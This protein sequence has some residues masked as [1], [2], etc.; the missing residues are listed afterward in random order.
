MIDRSLSRNRPGL[1]ASSIQSVAGCP[2]ILFGGG[3]AVGMMAVAIRAVVSAER[4]KEVSCRVGESTPKM[5][6][7]TSGPRDE[8][9]SES[10]SDIRM[11][12]KEGVGESVIR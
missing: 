9:D 10:D 11:R 3:G 2:G 8:R 12:E 4:L 1:L 6:D 5:L 7:S